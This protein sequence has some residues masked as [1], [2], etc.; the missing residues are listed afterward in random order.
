MKRLHQSCHVTCVLG[1]LINLPFY[2]SIFVS[3]ETATKHIFNDL[4]TGD[5]SATTSHT[6]PSV[7]GTNEQRQEEAEEEDKESAKEESPRGPGRPNGPQ[8]ESPAGPPRADDTYT[9]EPVPGQ[10]NPPSEANP[11]SGN[12]PTGSGSSSEGTKYG[13]PSGQNSGYGPDPQSGLPYLGPKHGQPNDP[14]SGDGP[15]PEYGSASGSG[16]LPSSKG[17]SSRISE[18]KP[19]ANQLSLPSTLSPTQTRTPIHTIGTHNSKR[20]EEM[21]RGNAAIKKSKLMKVG[22]IEQS[23][24]VFT[25]CGI[26]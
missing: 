13:Q 14:N 26:S 1:Y 8:K 5:A 9:E 22:K 6:I 24:Y 3:G 17:Q 11:T 15:G 7:K 18:N 12:G 21:H 10:R 16:K 19:Y 23:N 2:G 20:Y 4:T 25:K